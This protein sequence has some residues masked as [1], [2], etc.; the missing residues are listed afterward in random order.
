MIQY[1]TFLRRAVGSL[2]VALVAL[3]GFQSHAQSVDFTASADFTF[4]EQD[5]NGGTVIFEGGTDAGSVASLNTR[6]QD[7]LP[8]N[9]TDYCYAISGVAEFQLDDTAGTAC[10]TDGKAV[11]TDNPATGMSGNIA[12]ELKD[13][14]HL[15]ADSITGGSTSRTLTVTGHSDGKARGTLTVNI[16]VTNFDEQPTSTQGTRNPAPVWYLSKDDSESILISS[17]FRDPEGAPVYFDS[18]AT[19]TDVYVC[20]SNTA[21]DNSGPGT[22]TAA[23]NVRASV[24]KADATIT[25]GTSTTGGTAACSVSNT[26]PDTTAT[27]APGIPGTAGNRVVTTRKVGPILHITANSVVEDTSGTLEDPNVDLNDRAKGTY[28]AKVF[29]RVWTG[30]D[31]NRLASSDW[32]MATVHVKVGANNLPQFAGGAT[33]YT[34]EMNENSSGLTGTART[35]AWVAGDLDSGGVNNDT[36]SYSLKGQFRLPSG[37][38]AVGC[39][40]GVVGVNAPNAE[41]ISL[42]GHSVDYETAQSCTVVL[43]VTDKWSDPQE[44]PI[45]ITIKDVNEL[46]YAKDGDDDKKIEDQN[47]VNGL[48]R[49][50]DL[51]DYFVDPEDDTI[52]Y[53]A[54]T[55][56]YTDVAS[57]GEGNV[58][59][60]TGGHATATTPSVV[61]VTITASDGK[62]GL[63]SHDFDVTS[64]HSNDPPKITLVESGTI[65]IGAMID[66]ADSA[67]EDLGIEIAFSDDDPKPSAILTGGSGLFEANVSEDKDVVT[68]SVGDEA[69]NYEAA[70]RHT[71]KLVLQDSWD[72]TVMSK[73]LEIQVQVVD[74]NDAPTSTL[75]EDEEIADQAIVVNGSD[76]LSTG[77]YFTDED[78]DRLLID[79][80]SSDM[81]KVAVSVSGL[82]VVTFSGV[83]ETEE[84]MPVTITLTASDPEGASATL[85][86]DVT[87]SANNPPVADEAAFAERLPADNT[88]NVGGFADIELDGL[89]SD[90]D[91][92][93]EVTSITATTS[94]SNILMVIVED[95]TATLVGRNSG[96]ATLTITA[97]DK[98]DHA[99]PTSVETVITVN[100]APEEATPLDPQTLDRVTP[101]VVDVSGVFTDSDDGDDSLTITAE[102]VGDGMDRV[103]LGVEG[104]ELTITG[105]AGIEPGNVEI[106]LRATDPHGDTAKSTFVATTINIDPTVANSVDAQELDRLNPITVDVSEVFTDID[107]DI[108]TIT[109]SVPDDAI[110]TVG[111]IDVA[112]GQLMVSALEDVGSATVT[113]EATDNNGGMVTDTFMVTV[114]NILPTVAEGMSIEAQTLDRVDPLMVNVSGVF[115]DSDGEITAITASVPDDSVVGVGMIDIEDGMLTVTGQTLGDGTVTLEA[116]DNNG[117]MVTDTFMVTVVNVAPTVA[118]SVEAMEFTRI[119]PLMVDVSGVFADA[120]GEISSITASVPEDAVVSVGEIDLEDGM[121]TVTGLAVGGATVTLEATDND[122]GMVSDTFMVTVNNVDPVV[123]NAL[124]D[125]TL[126]RTMDLALDIGMTFSDPDTDDTLTLTVSVEHD[127]IASAMVTG[128]ILRVQGL[129]VGSTTLTVTATDADGGSISHDFMVE[130]QNIKPTVA[131]NIDDMSFDRLAPLGIDLSETFADDDGMISTLTAEVGN[132]SLIEAMIEDSVLTLTALA[133]GT[134]TITLT[135]VDDN[136]GDVMTDFVVEVINIEPVVANAVADQ[137]TTR[138]A[139]LTVDISETFDD[140]DQDNSMLSIT[141]AVADGMT[142]DA[143]LDGHML[144]ISGLD[145]GYTN[146]TLTATDADGGSVSN[147][148]MTTIENVEPV[149]ANAVMDQTTTRIDD[150]TV[151]I[152]ATFDD[153]DDDNSMLSIS[154]SVADGMIA[155]AMLDG[156]SLMITGLDVGYTNV[157]LTAVDEHGGMVSNTFMTTVDNVGPVVANA[158]AAQTTTRVEDVTLD[159]SSAFDDPDQDNGLLAFSVSVE[160]DMIVGAMLDGDMLTL[161]GLEVGATNVTVTATDEDGH[162]ASSTFVT[163]IE[164]VDPVVANSVADQEMDRREPL[165]LD[166]SET[167]LDVDDGAPTIT[168]MIRSGAVLAASDVT[169]MTLSLTALAVGETAVTLTATD[170]NGASVSDEFNVTVINIEPVVANAVADQTTTRVDDLS[171]DVSNTFDDPD[172]DNSY[173]SVTVSVADSTYVDA[174]ISGSTLM[175]SGLDVGSTMV[176]L[177][178]TDADGGMVENTFTTTIDNIAP[179]VANS[180]SPINLEVG[181]Q[182]ASQAI[183]GL[184][185]DDGDPLTYTI[186]SANS[187]IASTMISGMTAM[188]GPVS[189]GA[190]TFTIVASDPH[191]GTASVTGSVTVGDGELKAVAAKS[192]AGFG[193]ALLASVSSSVGSRVVLDARSSDLTLDAWAPAENQGAMA[194][195]MTAEDRSDAAW[196]VVNST[197]NMTASSTAT[198]HGAAHGGQM[199]S[200]DALGSMFGQSFALNLGSSDNPS[201]WSVWA[202]IDRQSYEGAGYDGMASSV[203]L[204]AD[205]TVAECWMFGVAI[206]SNSGESDYSWGTATQTM[207][208]SLTTVLPY[209]SYQPTNGSSIWGVAGFGSG[210][211]DTTV[212]GASNDVSDLSS[213]LTMVGGSQELTTV[214]RLNL[215]LRG[216]AATVSLETEDGNGAADGLAADVN[217]IRIGLEGS[218]R[219]ETGQGGMLEPFGQ[220]NLRSDGGDGDTGTGIEVAGGVRM[221]SDV[222]TLEVQGRTLAMHGADEYSESGFS[223][224][225]KLNPSASATGVSVSI[226]PRW[227]ADALG[228]GMLWQ[229]TLNIGSANTYGVLT[230]FGNSGADKSI[231][232]QI[233]Y[234]I[235]VANE[236]YLLTPFVDYGVSDSDR[237]EL[238]IGASL[239]QLA[240]ND[241]ML[242]INLALGRV[243]ERTGARSG[244]IG[245]NATL[246]F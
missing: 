141:V 190:T 237:R 201:R 26:N 2:L 211:L 220:V 163:T 155:D 152:S 40:G 234:G 156:H 106:V 181:G 122:G 212:V 36:L 206:S 142:A 82:D 216:D 43:Q 200:L 108:S 144:T 188:V 148:F 38:M 209:I 176:T 238:L 223:L 174:S 110:I 179:V 120:D 175:I 17:V 67:G 93:D 235:M 154:V 172:Q 116:T 224:M 81:T 66:E 86:F 221:T 233:G 131:M 114:N 57:L 88:V 180:I 165:V 75:E 135:A 119:D 31:D 10:R 54:H 241:A 205:V 184:F 9:N 16:T 28:T 41:G 123:A 84:D 4:A 47:M 65:A 193:R 202:D 62:G 12:V 139:D 51:D 143:M 218:F 245:L 208:L 197:T 199:S 161:S 76:S 157:T 239:R 102:A 90:P 103:T 130:V 117:G 124:M 32:S 77:M 132:D 147:T 20:D 140:P 13:D 53:T 198:A 69:L 151:D 236:Q 50:F 246:R 11:D 91:G 146:V 7:A 8:T 134:T 98:F 158:I 159:V 30:G 61:T 183:A 70:D 243:E 68:I 169:D 168:V 186:S 33:G 240:Q 125:E 191:G 153:P 160:D 136:G 14:T 39:A 105:V 227:G 22:S 121:L 58:L 219:T 83:A 177:T 166:L 173:L 231:D 100:A 87:V 78:G 19:S 213:T 115:A 5:G 63:L 35:T 138:I 196:N 111:D 226:A 170:V 133:V 23:D 107:G 229:D 80:D 228:N 64:R 71:L 21:G 242:D 244:K 95:G 217:R 210:E 25:A 55:N 59:T 215:A 52:T 185:S 48:T 112:D 92:G 89:F 94:D 72:E 29:F 45:T 6:I 27:P 113:L 149:V 118:E 222:F 178:A 182:S 49:E 204:G 73:P 230:G 97:M 15:D 171:I 150:L 195:N 167:F 85:E 60:I 79:A 99:E 46:N 192:L 164:N 34:A 214:G 225:A 187:G 129:D 3:F 207:D 128:N 145:V 56:I 127:S 194:M 126:T 96:E 162:S 44:V 137:T 101:H 109:A 18:H 74:S 189:R 37:A 203:Y 232:T 42:W 24:P 1:T 104:F